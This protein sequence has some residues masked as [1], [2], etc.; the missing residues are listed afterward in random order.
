MKPKKFLISFLAI[1]A[2]AMGAVAAANYHL[3]YYGVFHPEKEIFTTGINDRIAKMRYLLMDDNFNKYDSY[4]WGSSRVMKTDTQ[5]TGKRTYNMGSP[6]GMFRDCLGQLQLLIKHRA[7]IDTVYLGI[8]DFSYLKDYS[9]VKAQA[10]GYS[11]QED[12]TKDAD[13]FSYYLFRPS[14]IQHALREPEEASGVTLLHQTGTRF[15]PE[16]IE[17]AIESDPVPYVNSSRFSKGGPVLTTEEIYQKNLQTLREIISI[18]KENHI[19]L[20]VFFNPI[21]MNAYLASDFQWMQR[22]K[23]DLSKL[24]DFW[25]FSGVNYVTEN[26]YFWYDMMHPRA[27]ICDKILDT[28]SGQ[29]KITW[30]PDFGV[31]VTPENVD[32]FC[33]KAVRDREAYDPN[34]KQWVPTAEERA[35]M[36]KRV[37]YP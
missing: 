36:T 8:D 18:C 11:Y 22:F 30:V 19:Q 25:D 37:N 31:Y 35:V 26:N 15:V 27:F 33:E 7:P 4:L 28:V 17:K 21:Q 16:K 13:A 10:F 2:I 32:A 20:K 6:S 1:A 5:V 29:H 23:K 9:Y 12:I 14:I 3:D 24:T 34:H